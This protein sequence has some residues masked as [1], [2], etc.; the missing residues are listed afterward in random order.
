MLNKKVLIMTGGTISQDFAS[1]YLKNQKF[2][3][4]IAVDGGLASCDKLELPVHYI[5]G[6]FDSVSEELLEKYQKQC[7]GNETIEIKKFN[8]MKDDT[9]TQIA[10]ELAMDL[11][12][13]EIVIMGATGTRVDHLLANIHILR[14]PLEKNI[15]SCLVDEHNKIYLLNRN[16]TLQKDQL[17]GPYISLLPLT[18]SVTEVTLQGFQY[19]L[20]KRTLMIGESIGISNEVIEDQ[21][22][23][24]FQSGILIVIESKD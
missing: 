8:P 24:I 21:A 19:P 10:V 5:V 20:K 13:D 15:Q 3:I 16:T 17:Y 4:V 1:G 18:E 23:I 9:D 2:D 14:R 7:N 12:A 6:D 11:K 22:D